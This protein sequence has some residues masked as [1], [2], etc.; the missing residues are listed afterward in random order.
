MSIPVL[1]QTYEEVRR[2]AIAGSVVAPGD[3]RLKKL[4][5]VLEQAGAKAP[6]FAKIGQAAGRLVESDEKTSA[7]ALLEL[8]TLVNAVLYTQGETGLNGE[9]SP[10][11]TVDLGRPGPQTSARVLKPLQD[12][13]TTT[14]GGR[15]EI[16]RDAYERGVFRDF[17]LISPALAAIDD[18]YAEIAELIAQH[19]LP[20]YGPAI[21]PRLQ[22]AFDPQGRAGHARRL[23][24]MHRLDPQAAQPCVRRALDEGTQEIRIAAIECLGDS[25]ADLPFLL[26]QAKAKAAGVRAAA[27]RALG[28]GNSDNGVQV[29]CE[30]IDNADLALAVEPIRFSPS[31]ALA[32]FLHEAAEKQFAAILSGKGTSENTLAKNNERMI[33]LLQC[34]SGREDRNSEPLLIGFF[35]QAAR[36]VSVKGEPSGKDVFEHLVAVMAAGSAK[37]QSVLVDAHATLS[38][39]TLGPAFSAACQCRK[40]AEVFALFSPY[41]KAKVDEKKKNRDP[42]LAKREQIANLLIQ[43][44]GRYWDFAPR[45]NSDDRPANLDPRWLDLAVQLERADLVMALAVPDHAKTNKFLCAQFTKQLAGSRAVHDCLQIVGTMVRVGHPDA[46][47]SV[48]EMIKRSAKATSGTLFWLGHLVRWLPK[49]EAVPK[50]EALLPML[51]EKLVDELLGH[52]AELKQSP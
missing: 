35:A 1:I 4:L 40:P 28:A 20:L 45:G 26:E 24:L 9:L 31:P 14:G 46:C 19:V 18:S 50:L 44:S 8:A 15:H 29:L 13:L 33:L 16:I 17:R 25:P 11:A 37:L 43:Q 10:I 12:A 49:A 27:L 47:D 51:P 5:P 7:A 52:L 22:E 6:V 2:L 41:L 34:L 48:V 36:L 38:P 39:E 32:S 23:K 30:C 21:V 3:F 42:A